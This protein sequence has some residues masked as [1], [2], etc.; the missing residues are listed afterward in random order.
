MTWHWVVDVG[1]PIRVQSMRTKFEEMTTTKP[2]EGVIGVILDPIVVITL[3]PNMIR[4]SWK[5][6]EIKSD[7]SC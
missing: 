1:M 4:P 7:Q 2:R 3:S 6:D 5:G